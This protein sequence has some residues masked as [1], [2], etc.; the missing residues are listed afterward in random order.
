MPVG[1]GL[2]DAGFVAVGLVVAVFG[3][4]LAVGPVVEV[5]VAVVVA[6]VVAR[7]EGTELVGDKGPLSPSPFISSAA[8]D[9]PATA[10]AAT[11]ATAISTFRVAEREEATDLI[12]D[13]TRGS[14]GAD[15]A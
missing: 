11:S 9:T 1:S 2:G 5:I 8:A 4:A 3:G 10:I 12:G 6:V 15:G 14:D 7:D 13:V